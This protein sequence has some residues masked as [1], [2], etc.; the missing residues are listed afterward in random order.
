MGAVDRIRQERVVAVL[1]KVEDVDA[2]VERLGV[3]VVEVTLDSPGALEAIRRLCE[4]G[5][6]TVL[7]GTVRT[8]EEARAAVEAGAE[9][10]V[11][12]VLVAGVFDL[13]VP[14][15]PGAFTASEIEAAWRAGAA[16]VKL[17]PGSLGGPAYVRAVLAPLSDVPLMVTGGVS[18][19][20][21]RDFLDAGAVA[22]GVDASRALA[23]YDAVRVGP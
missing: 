15:I 4:R 17:F 1:R 9:A 18:A 14:V 23:V 13:G 19:D 11:S 6:L 16:M 8:V 2:T 10:L 7:A 3:P 22:V 5:G 12:P 20:N 21:A